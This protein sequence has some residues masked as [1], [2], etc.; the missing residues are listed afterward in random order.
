M[1]LFPIL[2]ILSL[3]FFY[4]N[5]VACP[6]DSENETFTDPPQQNIGDTSPIQNSNTDSKPKA[7]DPKQSNSPGTHVL[8]IGGGYSASGNQLSLE[9][10]VKYFRK[11]RKKIHLQDAQEETYF[12]DGN[13]SARDLQYFDPSYTVPLINQVLAEIF[14]N[15]NTVSHQY[16]TN[17]LNPNGSA[18]IQSIDQW[19][20]QRKKSLTSDN[21]LIYFT[22]HGG[23][24]ATKTP[25]NTTAYLW[26]NARLKVSDFVKKLDQLPAKQST[27]LIMVQCYSGGFANVIFEDGDPG[28]RFTDRSR[29]G[30]FSTIQSRVAAGCT[31]DIRE[32]NYREYSTSFWEAL[33]GVTRMGKKI[34]KPDYD[35]DGK[36]S[37]MEAHSYVCIHSETIDIPLKTS[38]VLLRKYMGPKTKTTPKKKEDKNIL[39]KLLTKLDHYDSNSTPGEKNLEDFTKTDYLAWASSE[40]KAI[41]NALSLL[42]E[43]HSN[44]PGKDIKALQ[45]ELKKEKDRLVKEKKISLDQK[46]KY[47]D[48]LRKRLKKKYPELV[49]PYHGR[50]SEIIHSKEKDVI[51][52]IINKQSTWDK[53]L[54][55]KRKSNNLESDKFQIEKKEAKVLRLRRCIENIFLTHKLK[56]KGTVEQKNN[57]Q[58]LQALERCDPQKQWA[59]KKN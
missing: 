39:E 20:T 13:D 36:T 42:L 44:F 37:L 32:E 26:S 30:F 29:A 12:A 16:R 4:L 45:E 34:E 11:V 5:I 33:S 2:T 53:L 31:P 46:N 40:E 48:E 19:L 25:H 1:K 38:D 49:N 59:M 17:T 22:G 56:E 8:V 7:K 41:F 52:S 15:P 9:S 6:P 10:N 47:R 57:F 28:K 54:K 51:L 43:L 50:V 18:S 24:G 23:K 3:C 14:G 21:N 27:Y 35:D 58:K 55:A